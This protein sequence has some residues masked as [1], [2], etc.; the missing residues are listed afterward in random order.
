MAKLFAIFQGTVVVKGKQPTVKPADKKTPASVQMRMKIFPYFMKSKEAAN[1][2]PACIQIVFDCLYGANSNAKMKT[3]AIQFVHH[4][5]FHCTD[6]KFKPIGPVLLS[7]MVKVIG[8]TKEDAKLR[9][10]AYLAVGK[11]ARRS[12]QLVTKDIALLQTFFNAMC[13]VS[14]I[15]RH[16]SV[17]LAWSTCFT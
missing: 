4:L 5:C 3:M 6:A 12:P 13:L 7:G 14:T 16:S 11:L 2:F 17:L 10:L 15:F 9:G 8:D 1:Q